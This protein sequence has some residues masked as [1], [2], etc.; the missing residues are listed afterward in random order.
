MGYKRPAPIAI[1][2]TKDV[3]PRPEQIVRAARA[4]R[5]RPSDLLREV[6]TLYERMRDGEFDRAP[7]PRLIPGR[8]KRR[9]EQPGRRLAASD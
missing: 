9:S 4:L 5:C 8:R 7:L 3:L 6:R 2:E 1:W